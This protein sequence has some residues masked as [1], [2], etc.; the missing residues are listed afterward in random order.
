MRRSSRGK[1]VDII[2][3]S[4]QLSNAD[5]WG[6]QAKSRPGWQRKRQ[7]RETWTW[8]ECSR[9]LRDIDSRVADARWRHRTDERKSTVLGNSLFRNIRVAGYEGITD[10][11]KGKGDAMMLLVGQSDT[12][13]R[14]LRPSERKEVGKSGKEGLRV[15]YLGK[16]LMLLTVLGKFRREGGVGVGVG[17]GVREARGL[18]SSADRIGGLGKVDLEDSLEFL[19]DECSRCPS[20]NSKHEKKQ[21]ETSDKPHNL[22]EKPPIGSDADMQSEWAWQGRAGQG[23]AGLGLGTRI[24]SFQACP[25]PKQQ[26]NTLLDHGGRGLPRAKSS[27][28]DE[29]PPANPDEGVRLDVW[30]QV[31]RSQL[32]QVLV[33]VPVTNVGNKTNKTNRRKS[34]APKK[35]AEEE[36]RDWMRES[37][38]SY[39]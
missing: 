16:M 10:D 2:V 12:G 39:S 7:V 21:E 1:L 19:M 17:V 36:P 5:I 38:F 23:R 4:D 33:L 8:S 25:S 18:E 6:G 15:Q 30:N 13:M 3:R 26:T 28:D 31:G 24:R 29:Q 20:F 22:Y 9:S 34:V 11:E 14:F 27:C 37:Y 32:A 35:V